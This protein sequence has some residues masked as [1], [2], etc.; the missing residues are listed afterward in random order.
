MLSLRDAYRSDVFTVWGARNMGAVGADLL[1]GWHRDSAG[2][3]RITGS[4]SH[5]A[6]CRAL[7]D[8]YG[9][10]S[11]ISGNGGIGL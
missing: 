3:A 9:V 6:G 10:G 4:E 8:H 11:A 1:V 7:A 5:T 2:A